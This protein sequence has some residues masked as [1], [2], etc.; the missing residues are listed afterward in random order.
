MKQF[1]ILMICLSVVFLSCKS[2]QSNAV[3]S[4][5]AIEEDIPSEFLQFYMKFHSDSLFQM[6]HI[7]FPIDKKVDGN[8]WTSDE[9]ILH[10]PFSDHDG[11]YIQTF[12]NFGGIIIEYVTDGAGYYT[13][14]KRYI[15]SDG[16]YHLMYYH[17][18]N[19]F[20]QDEEW[21]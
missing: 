1:I 18:T 4:Q 9:W 13:M 14:E 7:R 6:E 21:K 15:R 10:K 11:Q 16:E 19:V 20:E 17:V 2:E 12:K 5:Q 3:N 8:K